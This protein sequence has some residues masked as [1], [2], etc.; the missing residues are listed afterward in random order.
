MVK[1]IDPE[2]GPRDGPHYSKKYRDKNIDKARQN[3][4]KTHFHI[5]R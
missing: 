5:S 2:L 1:P 4:F 3:G